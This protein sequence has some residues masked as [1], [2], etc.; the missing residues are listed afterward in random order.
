MKKKPGN[1]VYGIWYKSI[2]LLLFS[3]AYRFH[4]FKG[5]FHKNTNIQKS[6]V[7]ESS[8]EVR[9]KLDRH[10]GKCRR[11]ECYAWLNVIIYSKSFLY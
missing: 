3:L 10:S 9:V 2:L 1:Q 5:I 6:R 8:N 4:S 7:F 11:Y